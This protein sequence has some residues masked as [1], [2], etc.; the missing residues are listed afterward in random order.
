MKRVGR[1]NAWGSKT[2]YA[3]RDK[4]LADSIRQQANWDVNGREVRVSNGTDMFGN[5]RSKR[6][7]Q[8]GKY[9]SLSDKAKADYLSRENA[10]ADA[11]EKRGASLTQ[12][13]MLRVGSALATAGLLGA[14]GYN[15]YRATHTDRAARKAEEWRKE[16]DKTFGTSYSKKKRK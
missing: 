14:A 5:A 11:I 6:E 13:K 9:S 15:A 4:S 2:P 1:I 10:R 16:I 7:I 12:D 8:P 3:D